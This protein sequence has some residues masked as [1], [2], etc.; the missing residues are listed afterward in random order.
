MKPSG[1]IPRRCSN[2]SFLRSMLKT[3]ELTKE[4]KSKHA[5]NY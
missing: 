1:F 5:R 2:V 4:E 3:K